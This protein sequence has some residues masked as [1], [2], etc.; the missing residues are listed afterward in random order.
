MQPP[1]EHLLQ[2]RQQGYALAA[3]NAVNL[4][5]A[6]AIIRAAEQEHAPVILQIS[7]NAAKYAGLHPLYA[8]A[9]T[10]KKQ[11]SVPIILHYDHAETL[12]SAQ[13]ALTL[14]FDSIMLESADLTPEQNVNQL[15]QLTQT[16]KKTNTI[17]E[18][19]F[20]IVS[21]N[22]RQGTTLTPQT[23][24]ELASASACDTVAIDIG[25]KHKMTQKS[26]SLD[27][28]RLKQIAAL[29]PHPLVLHGSSGVT[30]QDLT[31]AI[32]LGISKVNIATELMMT[33]TNSVRDT[34]KNPD[35][36]DP[37]KYLGAARD[38]M[39]ARAQT[40]IRTLGSAGKAT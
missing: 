6:Q 25:T 3:F 26:A 22:E 27:L 33:F 2:A 9:Q 32:K 5:T 8:L 30:E 17:I 36:H 34:L 7:E 37:R 35:E 40:L 38:A 16:A 29:V 39:Q 15:K 11:A 4:E 19:E 28:E 24:L 21:K 31:Q 18:G 1:H 13:T 23:I 10:L 20:E 12:S 14:G